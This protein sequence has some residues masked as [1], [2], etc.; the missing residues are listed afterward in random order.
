MNFNDTIT[1]AE[2]SGM[3]MLERY[4]HPSGAEVFIAEKYQNTDP[5]FDEPHWMTWWHA[6]FGEDKPLAGR[7]LF[8]RFAMQISRPARVRSAKRDAD[9]FIRHV[10]DGYG[11]DHG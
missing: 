6:S 1:L 10:V 11:K 2:K 4:T 5:E 9:E 3:K 8:T 7:K